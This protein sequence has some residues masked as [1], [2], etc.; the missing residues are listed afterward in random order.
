MR[1]VAKDMCV[2][3]SSSWTAYLGP[4]RSVSECFWFKKIYIN[5]S[6]MSI[7]YFFCKWSYVRRNTHWWS[8][9][10]T[11]PSSCSSS[12]I[13]LGRFRLTQEA[14]SDNSS[15]RSRSDIVNSV[16][17]RCRVCDNL[18]IQVIR[19]SCQTADQPYQDAFDHELELLKERVRSCAQARME[20]AMKE[21]E[22]E[23]RQKRLGPGG[24]DPVEVYE[25][26]PKVNH[27]H[28]RQTW[29]PECCEV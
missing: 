20:S 9:W 4:G 16:L 1:W 2:R 27:P 15:Q 13:W 26:L 19:C 6:I 24:L 17:Y 22:E 28:T 5:K 8:R 21:I 7:T 29:R 23:E 18:S 3:K 12:W 10:P 25:T 14:A 11:R